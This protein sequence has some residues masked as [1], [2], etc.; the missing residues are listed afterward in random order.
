MSA[1]TF[2]HPNWPTGSCRGSP[3]KKAGNPSVSSNTR[4]MLWI[5]FLLFDMGWLPNTAWKKATVGEFYLQAVKVFKSIS[6]WW[7]SIQPQPLQYNDLTKF[8]P[9]LRGFATAQ[10]FQSNR[11]LE[12][13]HTDREEDDSDWQ[14]QLSQ[15]DKC[16]VSNFLSISKKYV[17]RLTVI[18]S[19][20]RSIFW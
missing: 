19:A 9:A 1:R 13:S 14:I 3:D 15:C 20:G 6:Y 17:I 4:N 11:S 7:G 2:S 10:A 8:W 5:L 12:L 18:F 16:I